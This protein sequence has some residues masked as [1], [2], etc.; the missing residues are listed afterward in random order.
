MVHNNSILFKHMR[1]SSHDAAPVAALYI[2]TTHTSTHK[3]CYSY[4]NKVTVTVTVTVSYKL[5]EYKITM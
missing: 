1:Y 4:R 5:P 3:N 2:H